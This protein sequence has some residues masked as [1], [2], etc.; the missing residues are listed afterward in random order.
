MVLQLKCRLTSISSRKWSWKNSGRLTSLYY[1]WRKITN[2]FKQT[3]YREHTRK[4]N[5]EKR[6]LQEQIVAVQKF[7]ILLELV[8]SQLA[9]AKDTIREN[10]ETTRIGN[11]FLHLSKD[12]RCKLTN[13]VQNFIMTPQTTLPKT[14]ANERR[15]IIVL[16]SHHFCVPR[17]SRLLGFTGGLS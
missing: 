10:T 17:G 5:E 3:K 16:S 14:S 11:D 6:K 4:A 13:E 2:S 8:Q 15:T 1:S 7:H 9:E 12:K